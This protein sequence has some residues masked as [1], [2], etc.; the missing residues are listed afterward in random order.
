MIRSDLIKFESWIKCA[1]STAPLISRNCTQT[2]ANSIVSYLKFS[3]Q[4][5]YH[6]ILLPLSKKRAAVLKL[7]HRSP[8]RNITYQESAPPPPNHELFAMRISEYSYSRFLCSH[9]VE[10]E[11]VMTPRKKTFLNISLEPNSESDAGKNVIILR[12]SISRLVE[13]RKLIQNEVNWNRQLR[14]STFRGEVGGL[15]SHFTLKC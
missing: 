6:D 2:H 3:L 15:C 11:A 8:K 1:D 9:L 5:I 10:N 13:E 4:F 12:T 7:L 14:Q